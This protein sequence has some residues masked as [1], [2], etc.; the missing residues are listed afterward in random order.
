MTA[1]K[2]PHLGDLFGKAAR[3]KLA[4]RSGVLRTGAPPEAGA[5]SARPAPTP[6]AAEAAA[7][8]LEHPGGGFG[9]GAPLTVPTGG[10]SQELSEAVRRKVWGG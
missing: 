4:Q 2:K 10:G 3:Q 5:L 1:A 6:D 7:E 9:G 8:A